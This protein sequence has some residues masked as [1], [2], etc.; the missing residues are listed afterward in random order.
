[1]DA[2]WPARG[3]W[4]DIGLRLHISP[5]TLDVFQSEHRDVKT[6]FRE[7]LKVWLKRNHPPPT[8]KELV[9]TLRSPIVGREDIAEKLSHLATI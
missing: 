4:Y 1:M 6:C 8:W 2:A 7:V 5:D 9:E 3:E